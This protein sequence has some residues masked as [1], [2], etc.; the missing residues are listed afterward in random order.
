MSES[1]S[2]LQRTPTSDDELAREWIERLNVEQPSVPALEELHRSLHGGSGT[3]ASRTARLAWV[4][5]FVSLHG[6]DFICM[7]LQRLLARGGGSHVTEAA[8]LE[9]TEKLLL[10]LWQLMN[11][12][13][14]MKAML[15]S[16]FAFSELNDPLAC[17]LFCM[18]RCVDLNASSSELAAA[19]IR[20]QC[21]SIKLL[22]SAVAYSQAGHA[23]VC[24]ALRYVGGLRPAWLGLPLG[25]AGHRLFKRLVEPPSTEEAV[26]C[27]MVLVAALLDPALSPRA[28]DRISLANEFGITQVVQLVRKRIRSEFS[29]VDQVGAIGQHVEVILEALLRDKAIVDENTADEDAA[30]PAAGFIGAAE[31]GATKQ[32]RSK[33]RQELQRLR[34]LNSELLS[35]LEDL[36]AQNDAVKVQRDALMEQF[37][38]KTSSYGQTASGAPRQWTVRLPSATS[39]PAMA[40]E[41]SGP[42]PNAP[43]CQHREQQAAVAGSGAVLRARPPSPSSGPVTAEVPPPVSAAVVDAAALALA[44]VIVGSVEEAR[45]P[46]HGEMSTS[47][48]VPGKRPRTAME[49]SSIV[50]PATL[51]PIE[52]AATAPTRKGEGGG[53][54]GWWTTMLAK[55]NSEDDEQE[56]Q[57][58]EQQRQENQEHL[59]HQ[60]ICKDDDEDEE[61]DAFV[62]AE[63]SSDRWIPPTSVQIPLLVIPAVAQP[64]PPPL[65]PLQRS[66]PP[67]TTTTTPTTTTTAPPTAPPLSAARPPPLPP[68]PSTCLQPPPI[69]APP[70]PATGS[71]LLPPPLVGGS[72]APPPP[73]PPLL[74]TRLP[75]APPPPPFP[76][77]SAPKASGALPKGMMLRKLHLL[78]GKLG[79]GSIS[80]TVWE[81]L[82]AGCGGSIGAP[83]EL[84]DEVVRL[85]AVAAKGAPAQTATKR[86]QSLKSIEVAAAKVQLL[87]PKSSHLK[88]IGIHALAASLPDTTTASGASTPRGDRAQVELAGT[89]RIVQALARGDPDAFTHDQLV[90]LTDLLPSDEDLQ[91]VAAYEGSTEALGIVEA[92]TRACSTLPFARERAKAMLTRSAF[93]ERVASLRESLRTMQETVA[94]VQASAQGGVLRRILQDALKLYCLVNDDPATRGFRLVALTRFEG[95]MSADRRINLLGYLGR[96]L[97]GDELVAD[98]SRLESRL[99]SVGR[100]VWSDV[101]HEVEEVQRTVDEL[102]SLQSTIEKERAS[103][104]SAALATATPAALAGLDSFVRSMASFCQGSAAAAIEQL[105]EQHREADES[106]RTLLRYL[107]VDQKTWSRPEETLAALHEVVL[108]IKQAHRHHMLARQRAAA[109]AA[110]P[111]QFASPRS[112]ADSGAQSS[113]GRT[114]LVDGIAGR[115]A[116]QPGGSDLAS[117]DSSA[118]LLRMMLRRASVSGVSMVASARSSSLGADDDGGGGDDDDDDDDD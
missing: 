83:D 6:A 30:H 25:K 103:T 104:T 71:A 72:G 32:P 89:I 15:S 42:L 109:S 111:Q 29:D 102:R 74:S 114:G 49:K 14:G 63:D 69:V 8:R 90:M 45:F 38:E 22:T 59:Q 107:A 1:V 31:P 53:L 62:D 64:P 11:T 106:T 60:Q 21:T 9:G 88:A 93:S 3:R 80:G 28:A 4:P 79:A 13:H 2:L 52:V 87:D 78:D 47:G 100:F 112:K 110:K 41:N 37:L 94:A 16:A 40:L 23:R 95:Y 10:C 66:P 56:E 61:D 77:S 81:A 20:V 113:E 54:L 26:Y 24:A 73:P 5:L 108:A 115:F 92:F 27:T 35:Q 84:H 58:E 65:L 55:F 51:D 57:Q 50:D 117:N 39:M 86:H 98:L 75:P 34:N 48:A 19:A 46:T 7:W 44:K 101:R 36:S 76:G 97:E 82:S 67:T 33:L 91:L 18:A 118:E 12:E 17:N 116:F 70:P 99:S 96:R 105:S 43:D 68:L 85:F